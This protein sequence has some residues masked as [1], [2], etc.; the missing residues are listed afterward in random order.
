[1]RCSGV[2]TIRV[3]YPRT[4]VVAEDVTSSSGGDGY[5]GEISKGNYYRPRGGVSP[6]PKFCI[7]IF[8]DSDYAAL[9]NSDITSGGRATRNKV[10]N[11]NTCTLSNSQVFSIVIMNNVS[12][13][14]W[15]SRIVVASKSNCYS[16]IFMP[17]HSVVC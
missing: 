13:T 17:E 6:N 7:R 1:M 10:E 5:V 4:A 14:D 9:F 8:V 3:V 15:N 2:V 12:R 11:S 16:S